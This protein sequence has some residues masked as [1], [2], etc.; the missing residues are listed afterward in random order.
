MAITLLRRQSDTPTVLGQDDSRILRYA[1]GG[2]DGVTEGYADECGYTTTD[3]TLRIKSGEI[4]LNGWQA[5]IDS[6]G[7]DVSLESSATKLYFSIYVEY[8]LRIAAKPV[9]AIKS[10]YDTASYPDIAVGEDLTENPYGIRRMLLYTATGQNNTISDVTRKFELCEVGKIRNATNVTTSI[11]GKAISSIFESDGTTAKKATRASKTTGGYPLL[12]YGNTSGGVDYTKWAYTNLT[13]WQ[14]NAGL[15][16]SIIAFVIDVYD[17]TYGSS[18][19][20]VKLAGVIPTTADDDCLYHTWHVRQGV[21]Y[22]L[23]GD[24]LWRVDDNN[25]DNDGRLDGTIYFKRL[26]D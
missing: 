2:Y 7:V 5:V 4:V 12:G 21:F 11:N 17:T 9:I 26:D 19:I 13:N 24:G 22:E 23:Y 14:S 1:T 20:S 18:P 6:S 15:D 3:S 16:R 10:Q 25:S 8:D